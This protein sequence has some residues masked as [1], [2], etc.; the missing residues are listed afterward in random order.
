V[1]KKFTSKTFKLLAK[2]RKRKKE[3]VEKEKEKGR[4]S[5]ISF[6]YHTLPHEPNYS[7]Y[8]CHPSLFY[9]PLF[10]IEKIVI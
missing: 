10:L 9:Y 5:P 2:E 8:F 7:T 1:K 3:R 6:N 4:K